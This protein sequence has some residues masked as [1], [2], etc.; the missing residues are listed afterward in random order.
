MASLQARTM[1]ID[2]YFNI[3]D[4]NQNTI[5]LMKEELIESG[6]SVWKIEDLIDVCG[7]I[8]EDIAQAL[9]YSDYLDDEM[10]SHQADMEAQSEELF[11]NK[12]I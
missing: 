3:H 11:K 7:D 4:A 6:T 12:K 1:F 5:D 9:K 8:P 2:W 10:L